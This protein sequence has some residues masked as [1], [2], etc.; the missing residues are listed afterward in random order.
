[1]ARSYGLKALPA[2]SQMVAPNCGMVS[3]P[4]ISALTRASMTDTKSGQLPAHSGPSATALSSH[5]AVSFHSMNQLLTV[6]TSDFSCL[7]IWLGVM[8]SE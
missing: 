7:A 5:G 1:M 6:W 2:S 4:V 3:W 8:P